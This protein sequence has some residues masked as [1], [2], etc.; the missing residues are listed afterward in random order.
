M[1]K[2]VRQNAC[3]A[4]GVVSCG[5]WAE[6]G[7]CVAEDNASRRI[8]KV[9]V[10]AQN[11][12]AVL[13]KREPLGYPCEECTVPVV[14]MSKLSEE[15]FGASSSGGALLKSD[16]VLRRWIS[17]KAAM[18]SQDY[19]VLIAQAVANQWI[20]LRQGVSAMNDLVEYQAAS[21][22]LIK[23]KNKEYS[24]GRVSQQEA[25]VY[26]EQK[27]DRE[28]V[29]LMNDLGVK[30]QDRI[31]KAFHLSPMEK[32]L[33]LESDSPSATITPQLHV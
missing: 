7:E 21:R 19:G 17:G 33:L 15:I 6:E 12:G 4:S 26:L 29:R 24:L 30:G 11:K 32:S 23:W 25:G 10:V 5:C 16:R 8:K 13:V 9:F 27:M 2:I 28:F 14:S 22:V 18:S 20:S 3:K 31:D 1:L